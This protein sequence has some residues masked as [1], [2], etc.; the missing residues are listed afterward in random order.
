MN[1]KR[2]FLLLVFLSAI[3]VLTAKARFELKPVSNAPIIDGII[4]KQEWD[5]AV[6]IEKFYQIAP[7]DNT[8]PTE[9]TEIAISY[10]QK[11]LYLLA[12]IHYAD[13]SKERAFHGSRDEIYTSDRIFFF[14]DTFG[15]NNQGYYIGA[16]CFGEQADGLIRQDIDPSIDIY[17][18]SFTSRTE[19][20]WILEMEVPLKSLN[21]KSG[22]N[23]DWGFFVKRHIN[24]G[25]EQ[26]SS[27]PVNRNGGNFY[28]NYGI[29]NLSIL[30]EKRNLKLIPA[31][32][33]NDIKSE[34]ALN[35]SDSS[36]KDLQPEMNLFYEPNSHL[37][38][39]ATLNPDFNTVEADGV[40]IDINQRFPSWVQE[41]RPFFIEERNPYQTDLNVFNTRN[42]INPIWGAKLSGSFN[43]NSFFMLAAADE[44]AVG[45]RFD[46]DWNGLEDN[47]YFVF[48]NFK[49]QLNK[50]D[51]FIRFATSIRSFN[52]KQNYVFNT[53]SYY[54]I[55]QI[56]THELQLATSYNEKVD[57]DQI[58]YAYHSDLDIENDKFYV[59]YEQT[60]VSKDFKADLGFIHETD[61]QRSSNRV[62]LHGNAKKES[63]FFH[64]WE[65]ANTITLKWDFQCDDLQEVY[66]EPMLGMNTR[67]NWNFW[68]GY[69]KT[70]LHWFEQDNWNWYQW[71]SIEYFP[72]KQIGITYLNVFGEGLYL[73]NTYSDP[74]KYRKFESTV[75]LRPFS[76]LDIE[77]RHKYH[78]LKNYYLVRTVE[79]KV[80]VQFHKNFWFRL[81]TQVRN[82]DAIFENEYKES[83]DIYP[84]FTYKP[85]SR[86]SIYLGATEEEFEN[87]MKQID[88]VKRDYQKI[89]DISGRT[90]FFKCSYTFDIL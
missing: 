26:I 11:N 83:I 63:D 60:G 42:I 6:W 68:I 62:E 35:N 86:V 28:D 46:Y 13:K 47:A 41:K 76:Q 81:I 30:P 8:E 23:V 69:E 55:N 20:G 18:K 16:N 74:Q 45:E 78:N 73:W 61:Y 64:Y 4:S 51:S 43:K 54:R 32:V 82:I 9:K 19:D 14:F 12:K 37:T 36:D 25:G 71:T 29:L 79:A 77:L 66:W 5:N 44:D 85:N 38:I 59:E 31:I 3:A 33:Y 58:G 34:D 24:D 70:M 65:I 21:Y 53:D 88:R 84:L 67:D 49:R 52:T 27:F 17:Y 10:D 39:T 57:E 40:G 90:W 2:N 87:E 22:K 72:I 50:D 75:F 80:K 15:S 7:G 1:K 89:E 48:A 56:A